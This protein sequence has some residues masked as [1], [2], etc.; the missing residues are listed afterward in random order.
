MTSSQQLVA[1]NWTK[2]SYKRGRSPPDDS[3][4]ESKHAKDS[5]HWLHSPPTATFNRLS[6]LMETNNAERQHNP[7]PVH[8]PKP[9]PIYIQDVRSIPPFLQLL[10]QVAS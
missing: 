7:S 3:D 6:P 4:R 1:P 2:A 5:Q 8:L 10:E 9:P